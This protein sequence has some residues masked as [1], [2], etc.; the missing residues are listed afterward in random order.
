MSKRLQV[1]ETADVTVTFEPALCIHSGNCVRGLPEVFDVRR[2][3]WVRP[4]AAAADAVM[5]QVACCPS[6]ALKSYRP[7]EPLPET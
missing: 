5:T 1:Y 3:R 6:G 4:E 7:G 2:K